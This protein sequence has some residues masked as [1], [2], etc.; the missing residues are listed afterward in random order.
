MKIIDSKTNYTVRLQENWIGWFQCDIQ[1]RNI[2]FDVLNF[3]LTNT[4][5]IL[6]RS[7]FFLKETKIRRIEW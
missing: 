5:K 3:Y 1:N 7:L 6:T 2:Y 4:I